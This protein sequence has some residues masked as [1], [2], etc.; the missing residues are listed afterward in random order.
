MPSSTKRYPALFFPET[1]YLIFVNL[2]A[3]Y[4]YRQKLKIHIFKSKLFLCKFRASLELFAKFSCI[5][6]ASLHLN[7]C[8]KILAGY[9]RRSAGEYVVAT[10]MIRRN[11]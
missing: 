8:Q 2:P 10:R 3:I 1:V 9:F 11:S 7:Q 6:I 4:R 5:C